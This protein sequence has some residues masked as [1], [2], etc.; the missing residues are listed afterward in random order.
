[1]HESLII[2][3]GCP[4]RLPGPLVILTRPIA[5]TSPRHLAKCLIESLSPARRPYEGH[6]ALVQSTLR[7]LRAIGHPVALNPPRLPDNTA[8]VLVCWGHDTIASTTALHR[9]HPFT[10][11]LAPTAIPNIPAHTPFLVEH[12]PDIDLFLP[13]SAWQLNQFRNAHGITP[14]EGR[15][16]PW[17][18]GVD[19]AFWSPTTARASRPRHLII[20]KKACHEGLLGQA[21]DTAT[22]AGWSHQIIHYGSYTPDSFRQALRRSSLAIFLSWWESQGIALAE[23]WSCDVPT[24]AWHSERGSRYQYTA[25]Y[26]SPATGNLYHDQAE[27]AQFLA[28]PDPCPAANPRAWVASHMTDQASAALLLHHLS[29]HHRRRRPN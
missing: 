7:G 5:P 27:L 25:P 17:P 15:S 24:L 20:Y 21:V 22:A 8:A 4:P 14:F 29:S 16:M 2:P 13:A 1:M 18:A 3:P 19:P 12:L 6:R 9:R 10:L 11:A 26:L 23:A 28:L